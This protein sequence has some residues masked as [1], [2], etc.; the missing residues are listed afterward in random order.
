[1]YRDDS[2]G[3][4][5]AWDTVKSIGAEILADPPK[6]LI[7]ISAHWQESNNGLNS[8]PTVGITNTDGNNSLIYDF[9]GFPNHMYEEQFHTKGSKAFARKIAEKLQSP[10]DGSKGFS[11]R[12]HG[13]RGVDH[14]LWVP[15]R[16]AFPE[17]SIKNKPNPLP[18]PVLQISLPSTPSNMRSH[19][20]Q[21]VEYDTEASY[22]LGKILSELRDREGED[23][24]IICSGMSVHNLGELWGL[25][26]K[27]APYADKFD[28][29][30]AKAIETSPCEKTIDR[31]TELF[32]DPVA[33]KAHPT[34]E[35]IMPIAVA[36]GAST[37]FTPP[38]AKYDSS[39][40]K[41][42]ADVD[43]GTVGPIDFTGKRLYTN[44]M[45]SMAWGIFKFGRK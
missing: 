2:F 12:L 20:P 22:R 6:A 17:Q 32:K 16:V 43:L 23:V 45:L 3:D 27:K 18:F 44:T 26:G 21:A 29:A 35:H 4:A 15:L 1:M 14:G 10:S 19:S 37:I 40:T 11:V 36:A 30:L 33:R 13:S 8:I 42:P 9:Y 31:L 28:S 25:N 41:P 5:G 24:T 7:V 34:L 39:L 38:G